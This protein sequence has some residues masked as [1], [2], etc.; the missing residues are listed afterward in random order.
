MFPTQIL[1]FI[2]FISS[3]FGWSF[4]GHKIVA[5]IAQALLPDNVP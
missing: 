2:L 5:E 3:T 4:N 1:F